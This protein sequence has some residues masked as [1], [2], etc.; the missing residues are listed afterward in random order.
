MKAAK[1]RCEWMGSALRY[2]ETGLEA[3][4]SR[5]GSAQ[6]KDEQIGAGATRGGAQR[7]GAGRARA[8]D[9]G[10]RPCGGRGE[11]GGAAVRR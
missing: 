5:G 6:G 1:R 8:R 7:P 10:T 2:V 9:G 4:G 11:E 3:H